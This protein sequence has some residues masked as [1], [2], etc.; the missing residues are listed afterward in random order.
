MKLVLCLYDVVG[1]YVDDAENLKIIK[2]VYELPENVGQAVLSVM[3][4][5]TTDIHAK[6][7]FSLSDTA[8][9]LLDLTTFYI[10]DKT[11]DAFDS[12]F[13]MADPETQV[14]Y[15]KGQFEQN[16]ELPVVSVT[17]IF[18]RVRLWICAG[19]WDSR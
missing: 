5:T 13:Y 7:R 18:Q 10:M 12:D 17:V 1:S 15:W 11:G 19:K 9:Q 3:N 4:Y 2:T 16:G 14:V 8:N 6:Y